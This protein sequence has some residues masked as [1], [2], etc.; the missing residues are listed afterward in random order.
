MN[1]VATRT[2]TLPTLDAPIPAAIV[3]R[4]AWK[5]SQTSG[6]FKRLL[7]KRPEPGDPD[8]ADAAAFR[9]MA[10]EIDALRTP[11]DPRAVMVELERLFAHYPAPVGGWDGAAGRERWKDWLADV[12]HLPLDIIR[13]ACRDYRRS[14]ERFAPSPGQWLAF[15]EPYVKGRDTGAKMLRLYADR[16]DE[17]RA[18]SERNA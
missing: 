3:E 8:P 5:R 9:N 12:G 14:P 15:A 1:A 4:P 17:Y 11:A 16:L 6:S 18:W 13:A 10:D 2:E 7:A